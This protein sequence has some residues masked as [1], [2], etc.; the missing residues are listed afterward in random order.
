[1]RQE[2]ILDIGGVILNQ[3]ELENYLEKLATTHNVYI[4]SNKQTY[5]I[6]R[7]LENLRAIKEVYNLLD[8]HAKLGILIH[9]AG[10]WLL[11][12]F[13]IIEEVAKSIEKELT[14]S[15]YTQFVGISTGKFAGFARIYVVAA[16]IVNYTDN[17]ITRNLIE[18][19]LLKYQTKKSLSMDEIWNVGLFMQIAIIE[20]I[21]QI[22]E[23]IYISQIEKYKVESIVERLLENKPKPEQKFIN[24][25]LCKD[26]NKKNYD[27]KYPFVEYMSYRLKKYGKQTES[28]L[29]VLEDEVE[30]TGA[31]VSE[32]IRRE[33]FDIAIQKI[34]IG[35]AITSIKKIQRINFL[36]VFEKI[37]GVEEIL[38][39][40]PYGAYEKMDYRTKEYYRASIQQISKKTRISEMYIAKKA[41]ELAKNAK[42]GSKESHIGYYLIT[43]NVNILYNKLGFNKKI[44]L[45]I[46]KKVR[47]YIIWNIVFTAIISMIMTRFCPDKDILKFIGFIL[48]FIPISEIVIKATQ[49]VLNKMVKPKLIPKMDYYRGIPKEKATMVVIPTIIKDKEK[50]EQILRKLEV[51][52]LA[53]KSK[54]L[55]FCLLG[56]CKESLREKEEYDNEIINKGV[57]QINLLNEKYPSDD[58]PIFSFIYR[59]RIWNEKEGSYLGWERKR[60][61]LTDFSEFLLGNMEEQEANKKFN[62]NTLDNYKL[63]MP[64]F[65]YIIT[66]DADTDLTLNSAFELVGVMAHPLN[67]PICKNGIVV[68]GYAL[69]QPRVGINLDIS[70]KTLFT[71]IFAGSGGIDCYSN[72]ISDTYQ[73][74]FAEGIFTG[75]GIFDLKIYSNL[76]KKEI[77]E[78]TVLS[79]DLLEGSYLRC[80]LATDIL[81]M[82]GYPTKY[83]SF[84]KRLS[85]WIRGDWQIAGWLKS[86]KLNLLSKYKILDNLRR[87]LFEIFAILSFVYLII[88]ENIFKVSLKW[89]M[90]LLVLCILFPY[91]IEIIN[92]IIFKKEGEQK[93]KTFAPK[94]DGYI[95]AVLRGIITFFCLPYKAYISLEA[96]CKTLYRMNISHKHLLEWVTSEEAE[97]SSKDDVISYFRNM[98][99]NC[100]FGVIFFLYAAYKNSV[101]GM[102]ISVLFIITPA[103]MCFISKENKEKKAKDE[104]NKDELKYIQEI[105]EKTFK[106]FKDNL[107]EENNYLIPDNFQYERKEEY[108]DR[109]SST[110]IGLSLIAVISGVDLN[111]ISLDEGIWLITKIIETVE[112]LLKWNGHLYN[113][114]NIKNKT[115]LNPRY[116]STVDSGNFVGYLYV[117]KVFLEE[118]N[119]DELKNVINKITRMIE[120][121]DFKMLYSSEHRLFSIGFNVEENK[122]TDSYYDLLASEAR[123]ASLIAI[124]KKDVPVKHWE[125]L[126]RT[127]TVLNNKKGL[128]SWSGTA[129]EYLMP[130]I[131]IPRYKGSLLDESIKFAIMSQMEYAEALNIPWG[132]SETAFSVKDLHS[133]YQYKAF[134]IPWLGLKRGLADD[135]VISSYASILAIT[136]KPKEVVENLKRLEKYNMQDKYG[137]FESIDFTPA[138]LKR[139]EKFKVV[140]TYMAHHQA[141]SL[142]SINNLINNNILQKRFMKNPEIEAV[143]ILLQEKMPERFIVT[144]EEKEK[145]K[146]LIYQNCDTYYVRKFK[147]IDQR[148]IE[149]NIISNGKYSIAINQLSQGVSK[150]D[151]IC[152]NRF[153]K[154]NDYDQGIFMYVKNVKSKNITT[155]GD[156]NWVTSFM[157]DQVHF[158]K[159]TE[160]IRLNLKIGIDT[161]EP[162]EIRSL[163]IENLGTQEEILEI[164]T[165]LEPI[166]ST[167]EQDFAH[168]AFNNL[169]LI[170][171]YDENENILEV[172][173][174]KREENQKDIY[175]ET[176]FLTNAETIVDN[177]FE[178]DKEKLNE[179]GNLK[180]PTAIEKSIPFSKKIGLVV[181]PILAMKKTIKVN[182]KQK[183]SVNLILSVNYERNIAIKNLLKYRNLENIKREFEISKAKAEAES[184]YL[185]IKGKDAIIY[186][187]IMGYILFDNPIKVVQLNNINFAKYKQSDLWKYGI[188][189]DLPIIL[190]RIRDS[191][192]IYV[193]EEVLKMYEYLRTKN[194]K[195]DIIFLDEEKHSYENY[196]KEEIE[197]KIL[198]MHLAFMRNVPGGIYVLSKNEIAEKDLDLIKVIAS[199]NIDSHKGDLKHTIKDLKEEYLINY[200]NMIEEYF[201]EICMKNSTINQIDILKNENKK[202]YNEY[203]AFS[204]DGKEYLI[205]MDKD[206]RL[207]TVWCNILANENLGTIVTENMGGYTWYKNSRLN[208]VSSWSNMAFLD[209]PSEI[210]YMQDK[211]T[212]KTWS[213]GLNPMP[214][215]N[216]YSVIYGFGYCKFIHQNMG[217]T[218]ELEVYVPNEDTIKVNILKLTNNTVERKKLKIIYYVKPVLGEDEI[219]TLGSIKVN[220][221]NVSNVVIAENLCENEF[222]NIVYV[223]SSEKIRSFTGNKKTFLGKGRNFK[224]RWIEKSK[225]RWTYRPWNTSNYC[226]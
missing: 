203:G 161:E 14:I 217:I 81:L 67:K 41:L 205:K 165:V 131:N 171:G 96:I 2:K 53:N 24:L 149:A 223:S 95:G 177:E 101:M 110:N 99:V 45:N 138:R 35:N 65:K 87:S 5:P 83:T 52:F 30:K 19:A 90:G 173:R 88:L 77:P 220:L 195:V 208:R 214:D 28:Y 97:K 200:P 74:N 73:D 172:K 32:V 167:K 153:K 7:M 215:E 115:P 86:K 21:R 47:I 58:I 111:Y 209:I 33:H 199:L 182:P 213:L 71:K 143:S 198:D 98:F 191:N 164:S 179:R 66:L 117:T 144:K 185:D 206:C 27:V 162:V 183:L 105:G 69:I 192:D 57:E 152:V 79:H 154:T 60:G 126:G 197:F 210:I 50:T 72:A 160:N 118:Q 61:A 176:C 92:L 6:P 145:P 120:N 11:D 193:I 114:Y 170:F 8:E 135:I 55:Y 221:D 75:K 13:Y 211:K 175:L 150:Y 37:N 49:Y 189:G 103:I 106:F 82:D 9:P 148:N 146:K 109:T 22:A 59:K 202:Y 181:E 63:N 125:L 184:R 44:N 204:E 16:S 100:I 136:D 142:L 201:E 190:V 151:D 68:D 196:V 80:G 39:Q 156:E 113:W 18:K 129:F 163:E 224:P 15:K 64:E 178:I 212:G 62:I 168:P 23:K 194:I 84:V 155:I 119:R 4:K 133:N 34:S 26:F 127:L 140:K 166:I 137:F 225:I 186:Q 70:Y 107:T 141:L 187:E 128:I 36:E 123:Q 20:N 94:I 10:E 147:K 139:N 180:I 3:E 104:L 89:Q 29:N 121:T 219:K 1:M 46:D 226:S 78:N 207:P 116:I 85:R 112:G 134:G 76:L 102:I 216:K 12:N 56:D 169:F 43:E 218:Q 54:N 122:L 124:A 174:K 132:I 51:Y 31:T 159:I 91:M 222:K 188:S 158:E 48:F 17:S 38:R 108:V 93:Q 25:K 157:P 42:E 40:D 130:N